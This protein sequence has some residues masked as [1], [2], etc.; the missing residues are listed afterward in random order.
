MMLFG[1]RPVSSTGCRDTLSGQ[2][3]ELHHAAIPF[4]GDSPASMCKRPASSRSPLRQNASVRPRTACHAPVP[5]LVPG[6]GKNRVAAVQAFAAPSL[7]A[8]LMPKA[9]RPCGKPLK[10][11]VGPEA[12][13]EGRNSK[14]PDATGGKAD[15]LPGIVQ[16]ADRSQA[17]ITASGR[18]HS[19]QAD[20][21]EGAA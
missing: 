17:E 8:A 21:A 9:S 5:R 15:D 6:R 18:D 16:S 10:W 11:A 7:S 1:R 2:N 13:L 4:G 12:A 20:G 3:R 19:L 14:Y